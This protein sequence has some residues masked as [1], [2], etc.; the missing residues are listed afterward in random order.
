MCHLVE[1]LIFVGINADPRSALLSMYGTHG[2]IGRMMG[3]HAVYDMTLSV[4]RTN[5]LNMRTIHTFEYNE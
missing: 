4:A 2:L 5:E 1:T 3:I